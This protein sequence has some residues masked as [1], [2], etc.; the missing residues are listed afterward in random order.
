[1]DGGFVGGGLCR[2]AAAAR[3][4][5]A[6]VYYWRSDAAAT[7]QTAAPA[8]QRPVSG[9]RPLIAW[10]CHAAI[11]ANGIFCALARHQLREHPAGERTRPR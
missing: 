9:G 11:A 5:I 8:G 10:T 2:C 1:M 6:P 7:V 3:K 4:A